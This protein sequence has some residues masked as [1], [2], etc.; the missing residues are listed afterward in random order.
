MPQDE[1]LK[2]FGSV[3]ASEQREQLDAAA[4]REVG[5]FGQHQGWPPR[6]NRGLIVELQSGA[7]QQLRG[8][9]RLCAPFKTSFDNTNT[10]TA[11]GDSRG[12]HATR[13]WF[14]ATSHSPVTLEFAH[15]SGWRRPLW[16]ARRHALDPQRLRAG[17]SSGN[18]GEVLTTAVAQRTAGNPPRTARS[19]PA[20]A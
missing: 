3:T 9:V 5:E 8:H 12:R 18:A 7:N 15:P 6:V 19:S 2:I 11:S 17:Q 4:Q 14:G 10:R 13:T 16:P 1:D 20:P